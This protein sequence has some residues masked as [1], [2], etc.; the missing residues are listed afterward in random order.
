M[1]DELTIKYRQNERSIEML[2]LFCLFISIY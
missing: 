1:S 2:R